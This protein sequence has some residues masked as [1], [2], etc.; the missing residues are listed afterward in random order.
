MKKALYKFFYKMHPYFSVPPYNFFWSK[1]LKNIDLEFLKNDPINV[2]DVGGR[3]GELPELSEIIKNINYFTFDADAK[4]A[5]DLEEKLKLKDFN[6]VKVFDNLLYSKEQSMD[7][8]IYKSPGES[9]IFPPNKIYQKNYGDT[10]DIERTVKLKAVTIDSLFEQKKLSDI[11]LFKLDTQGSELEILKGS[12]KAI[13]S[14]KPVIMEIEVEFYQMYEGQPLFHD[15]SAWLHTKGYE[16]LY[17]NRVHLNRKNF[18]GISTGQII[19]GDALFGIKD[20]NS[21]AISKK[22]KY[23]LLLINYGLIDVAFDIFN[24]DENLK[25][26][27]QELQD[28]FNKKNKGAGFL[29]MLTTAIFDRVLFKYLQIRKTNKLRYDSDR[30]YPIR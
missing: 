17:L 6:A 13:E 21:L 5:A 4:E 24:E 15:V 3:G 14:L 20:V 16:L 28:L 25:S 19:F 27:N 1:Y 12:A 23:I 30:S 22:V 11:D 29:S 9:S 7:F 18:K 10:F 8:H 2:V 26:S